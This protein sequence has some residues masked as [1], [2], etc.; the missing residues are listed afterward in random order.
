MN[1]KKL[2]AAVICLVL[3]ITAA[4]PG[5]L[6]VSVDSAAGDGSI[7][8]ATPAPTETPANPAVTEEPKSSETP[9]PAETEKSVETEKPVETEAPKTCTCDPAPA[10]GEAHKEGCPL[11]AAAAEKTEEETPVVHIEGCSDDCTA[12][13]CKCTCHLM[14]KIMECKTLE[15]IEAVIAATSEE[16]LKALSEEQVAKIEA[17]MA[18]LMPAPAP[19]IVI[20]ESEAPVES[21]VY[22]PTVNYTYVAPFGEPVTGGN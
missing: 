15:E 14:K 4:L 12:E 19:A 3:V 21:E 5:T 8:V 9:A 16:E 1:K 7:A 17:H 20:E 6:A 13:E 11:Y 22:N 2:I 10:E 18:K